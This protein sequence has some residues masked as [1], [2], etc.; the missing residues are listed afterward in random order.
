[1]FGV[2]LKYP[3]DGRSTLLRIDKESY[4]RRLNYAVERSD[5]LH[6]IEVKNRMV[7]SEIQNTDNKQYVNN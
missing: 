2:G 4:H 6:A 7:I 1:V 5:T 3:E